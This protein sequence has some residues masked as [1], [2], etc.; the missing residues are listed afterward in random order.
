M[1]YL[2]S[3]T[4]KEENCKGVGRQTGT[5]EVRWVRLGALPVFKMSSMVKQDDRRCEGG[6]MRGAMPTGCAWVL[7]V[8]LGGHRGLPCGGQLTEGPH[9]RMAA[10]LGPVGRPW[11]QLDFSSSRQQSH[12]LLRASP[13]RRYRRRRQCLRKCLQSLWRSSQMWSRASRRSVISLNPLHQTGP[14][15]YWKFLQAVLS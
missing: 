2:I 10:R 3:Q 7:I 6:G 5:E 4:A 14:A 1:L 8:E 13:I 9:L 11:L 12:R 15:L